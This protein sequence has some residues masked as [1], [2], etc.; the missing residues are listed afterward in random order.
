T[1]KFRYKDPNGDQSRL[2]QMVVADKPVA[3]ASVSTDFRFASAV[4]ELCMLLRDS[5]FKQQADYDELIKRA[6]G[7]KGGDEEGYRAEF[8]RLAESAK[9]LAKSDELAAQN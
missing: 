4:A 8:I 3:L 5:D 2:Q 6:K 9:L 7:A 1:V